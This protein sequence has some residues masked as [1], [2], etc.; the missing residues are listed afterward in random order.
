MIPASESLPTMAIASR[1]VQVCARQHME[2]RHQEPV[3][4]LVACECVLM[5]CLVSMSEQGMS[6][7]SSN[8]IVSHVVRV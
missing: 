2:C 1:L 8:V 3:R 4:G 6:E 7:Q 5:W